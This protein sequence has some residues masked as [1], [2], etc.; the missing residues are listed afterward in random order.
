MNLFNISLLVKIWWKS[1]HP[2]L[3]SDVRR[4]ETQNSHYKYRNGLLP[5]QYAFLIRSSAGGKKYVTR[6][7]QVTYFFLPALE[8]IKNTYCMGKRPFLFLLLLYM[9]FLMK[10][11][12]K[13]MGLSFIA[14]YD[15]ERVCRWGVFL[16]SVR[17]HFHFEWFSVTLRLNAHELL[18]FVYIFVECM[19]RRQSPTANRVLRKRKLIDVINRDIKIFLT[20][21][22]RTTP[23][24]DVNFTSLVTSLI[25][26][27]WKKMVITGKKFN[28]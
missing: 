16:H 20:T 23:M 19:L 11:Y 15:S 12:P 6:R 3:S 9:R 27:Q 28:I 5:M 13:T 2:L 22:F 14:D 1:V 21:Y 8:R 25:M 10:F 18:A 4:K 17:L 7:S 24:A 26:W